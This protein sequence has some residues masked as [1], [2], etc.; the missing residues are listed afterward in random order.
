MGHLRFLNFDFN[1]TPPPPPGT[2]F[3]ANIG[4][5]ALRS[6]G[7]NIPVE[8]STATVFKNPRLLGL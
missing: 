5:M 6:M 1:I 4:P 3:S 2:V 7:M 8:I